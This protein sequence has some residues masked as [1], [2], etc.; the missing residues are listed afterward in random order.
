[1]KRKTFFM[2]LLLGICFVAR[3]QTEFN[4]RYW[5]DAASE[6]GTAGFRAPDAWQT[7]VDVSMLTPS[8]HHIHIALQDDE[9]RLS[10]AYSQ[11]FYKFMPETGQEAKSVT[12]WFDD[13]TGNRKISSVTNG[14]F[15][16]EGINLLNAG[17]HNL[18]AFISN[19]Q[20]DVFSLANTVFYVPFYPVVEQHVK[21]YYWFDDDVQNRIATETEGIIQIDASHLSVGLHTLSVVAMTPD[22]NAEPLSA[23][24]TVFYYGGQPEKENPT[25]YTY[26]F[27]NNEQRQYTGQ[28]NGIIT[29]ETGELRNGLHTVHIMTNGPH[30]SPVCTQLFYKQPALKRYEYWVNDS[31]SLVSTSIVGQP[32]TYSLQA[33]LPVEEQPIGPGNFALRLIDEETYVCALNKFNIRFYDEND[34]YSMATAPYVDERGKQSLADVPLLQSGV[35]ESMERPALNELRWFRLTANANDVL[36]FMLDHAATLQL[37]TADGEEVLKASGNEVVEWNEVEAL[38]S[39]NYYV[40]VHSVTDE[41]AQQLEIAFENLSISTGVSSTSVNHRAWVMPLVTSTAVT[42]QLGYAHID[43]LSLYS[44]SGTLLASYVAVP[45]GYRL[46]VSRLAG[47]VYVVVATVN[48]QAFRQKIVVRH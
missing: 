7:E 41:E 23:H 12:Y 26:W 9:G 1:M 39:G 42:V 24:S 13:N 38:K 29:L 33:L 8:L 10:P 27:D 6:V 4:Y 16:V 28:L 44:L 18:S 48:G 2:V 46:D 3:G 34:S 15:K 30:P 31:P 5:F 40:A 19:S 20:G 25:G 21:L 47:G 45:D 11:L 17:L 36:R 37:F 43:N 32:Y 14:T 35:N 22:E